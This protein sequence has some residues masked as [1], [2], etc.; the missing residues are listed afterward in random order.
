MCLKTIVSK[1]NDYTLEQFETD[2]KSFYDY[3]KENHLTDEDICKIC[4]PLTKSIKNT[5][6]TTNVKLT[7]FVCVVLLTLY[8]LSY[9]ETVSWHYSAIGRII[10]I[11]VLP[12]YD[13]RYLKNEKCLIDYAKVTETYTFECTY[14]ETITSI[15][16]DENLSQDYVKERYI[17]MNLPVVLLD[18]LKNWPCFS[19]ETNLIEDIIADD[20]IYYS[21]P[22]KLS[23][24]LFKDVPIGKVLERLLTTESYF[25]HY[26]NCDF[27][28]T[29]ALRPYA[30][31]PVYLHPEIS[32]IQYNWLLASKN[33]NVSK[34]KSIKLNE[35]ITMIG[36]IVGG[37]YFRLI[38]I[39]DCYA[40]ECDVLDVLLREGE[41]LLFTSVWDL[42]YRPQPDTENVAV[43]LETH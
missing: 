33:Y 2:L 13:W 21:R 22:C 8:V 24:N 3:C 34:Y 19:K 18:S 35:R 30:P 7:F 6:L 12:L 11:N 36:Q 43:I 39:N 42:E 25:I 31:R 38:P 1:S 17:D 32:P 20:V 40:E 14:C 16:F 26:E 28:V 10:L 27:D 4:E 23:T 37:N 41:S 9:V 5:K 15:A 29:K